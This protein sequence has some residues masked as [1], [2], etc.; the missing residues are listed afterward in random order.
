[1]IKLLLGFSFAFGVMYLL[2]SGMD[3]MPVKEPA[4]TLFLNGSNVSIYKEIKTGCFVMRNSVGL[5]V[6]EKDCH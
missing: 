1:M 4:E 3:D 5:Q 2:F 6:G